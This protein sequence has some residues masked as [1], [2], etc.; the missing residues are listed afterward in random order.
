MYVSMHVCACAL[1]GG[2]CHESG[3]RCWIRKKKVHL[4]SGDMSAR[5]IYIYMYPPEWWEGVHVCFIRIC[6]WLISRKYIQH[7]LEIDLI[8][9]PATGTI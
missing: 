4:F 3:A 1:G 6:C 2:G 5:D 7:L 9:I 8:S